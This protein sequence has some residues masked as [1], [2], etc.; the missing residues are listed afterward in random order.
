V[1]GSR[2][3]T[4]QFLLSPEGAFLPSLFLQSLLAIT[5]LAQLPPGL[6][7]FSGGL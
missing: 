4:R 7:D 5:A 6:L 2:F 1:L 3:A